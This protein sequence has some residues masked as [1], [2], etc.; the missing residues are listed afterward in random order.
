M[1]IAIP[2]HRDTDLNGPLHMAWQKAMPYARAARSDGTLRVYR[3]AFTHWADW[4]QL[5]HAEPLPAT[6][7][8]V[9]TYLAQLARNGKSVSHIR[10]ALAAI[11]S[12]HHAAGHAFDR[13][14]PALATILAGITRREARPIRRAAPLEL[15]GL[16]RI[17]S[18]IAGDDNRG[19]RDRALLLVGF[20]GALRRSEICKLDVTGPSP[21]EISAQGLKLHL[22]VTKASAQTQSIALPRRFDDLCPVAAV[23]AYLAATGITSGPLFRAVSKSGRLLGRRLDA[24]SVRH[25]LLARHALT[26]EAGTPVRRLAGSPKALSPHSQRLT[27]HSLRAGFI[28]AAAKA[29]AP[30]HVIQRTS[31]HKS[32]EVLRSYIRSADAFAENAGNFL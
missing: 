23:E 25:I 2:S 7:A 12:A 21:I 24:T 29:G 5:M 1:A 3:H 9:A 26:L 30:E 15:D 28:T 20:F 14:D 19:K 18:A 31:R 17:V 16:R 6:A 8:V 4:C 32:V 13:K 11:Q 27:P 10:V 22:T